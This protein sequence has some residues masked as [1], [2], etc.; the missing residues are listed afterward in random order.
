MNNEAE[1]SCNLL[2]VVEVDNVLVVVDVVVV[3]GGCVVVLVVATIHK[4]SRYERL[5]EEQI[6]NSKN[7][8]ECILLVVVD[9]GS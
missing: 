5:D 2:V 7:W 3:G 1:M 4:Q 9:G 8:N 6:I